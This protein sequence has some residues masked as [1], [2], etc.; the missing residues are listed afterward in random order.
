M[1]KTGKTLLITLML[2]SSGICYAQ[3]SDVGTWFIYFGNQQINKRWNW[4]NEVQYRNYNFIGDLQQLLLR[5]GIGYNISENNNNVLLG[6]AFINSQSY[7]TD[8]TDK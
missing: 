6:Y 2:S 7:P 5:T 3:K 4:W 8:S 1:N